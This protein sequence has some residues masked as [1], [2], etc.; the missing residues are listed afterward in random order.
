MQ[1]LQDFIT[2]CYNELISSTEEEVIFA[3]QYLQ[4]RSLSPQTINKH[5]IGYCSSNITIPPEVNYY[6]SKDKSKEYHYFI[7]R[8]L[9]VPIYG[10]FG[11]IVGLATRRPVS[12]PGNTWWNLSFKKGNHLFLLDKA[13]KSIF[14]S[15]KIYLVEG[16]VDALILYQEGLKSV[17]AIM[18]T[19]LTPRKVGLIARYCN[20]VCLCLDVDK[21]NAGQKAQNKAI[22]ILS[23]FGFCESFSVID[24]IPQ[25]EDPD[26]FVIK[27][28]IKEFLN[29]ERKLNEEEV[30]AIRKQVQV[31]ERS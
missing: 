21:N 20:N 6:G 24:N 16:Y 31:E 23:E 7:R 10:E 18:G 8:R 4:S 19:A 15:N 29:R 22:R 30:K 11:N 5:Q 27:N 17:C 25:G 3:R 12:T 14:D 9:V 1:A 28:G 26:V 13:R 2:N